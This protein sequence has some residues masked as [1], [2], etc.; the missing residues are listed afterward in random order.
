MEGDKSGGRPKLVTKARRTANLVPMWWC[1]PPTTFDEV[2]RD[3]LTHIAHRACCT[4]YSQN[5]VKII[6]FMVVVNKVI[7][8][9][10]GVC[11]L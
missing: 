11:R 8:R 3:M 10:I 7:D 4:I 1:H 5:T 6:P 2:A 9:M